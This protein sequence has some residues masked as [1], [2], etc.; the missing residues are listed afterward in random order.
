MKKNKPLILKKKNLEIN[1][2]WPWGFSP[3]GTKL[4][5]QV[6]KVKCSSKVSSVK[7][8]QHFSPAD[9]THLLTPKLKNTVLQLLFTGLIPFLLTK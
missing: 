7:L 9:N 6:W 3:V 1:N 4:H 8:I 5:I 2:L